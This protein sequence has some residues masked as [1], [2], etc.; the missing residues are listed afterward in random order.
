MK[1]W[2]LL[3]ATIAISAGDLSCKQT[4]DPQIKETA[5][6]SQGDKIKILVG[7]KSFT[8]TLENNASAKALRKLLPLTADMTELNA[9][10]KYVDLPSSLP[11]QASNP[12][13]IKK[14]DLMLYGDATLVL[15]Y[16][17]FKTSYRYTRLGHIDDS[18]GLREALGSGNLSVRYEAE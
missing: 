3:L 17:D 11:T 6:M 4:N 14:G 18:T 15:F 8:A 13:T 12:G 2:F 7:N 10:E 9:N 5:I 16:E 1:Q